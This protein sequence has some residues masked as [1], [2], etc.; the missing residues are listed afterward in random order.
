[1]VLTVGRLC[2]WVCI[3]K[4][5]ITRLQYTAGPGVR[6]LM[7]GRHDLHLFDTVQCEGRLVPVA[8]CQEVHVHLAHWSIHVISVTYI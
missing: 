5:Y 6:A 1:M 8:S 7:A 3:S 2:C 4:L